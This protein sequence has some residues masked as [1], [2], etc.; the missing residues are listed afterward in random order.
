MFPPLKTHREAFPLH[1]DGIPLQQELNGFSFMPVADEDAPLVLFER[2]F[3]PVERKSSSGM[4]FDLDLTMLHYDP[5]LTI[6]KDFCAFLHY[7]P[8]LTIIKD[9][10]AFVNRIVTNFSFFAEKLVV[11]EPSFLKERAHL[12]PVVFRKRVAVLFKPCNEGRKFVEKRSSVIKIEVGPERFVHAAHARHILEA[13]A[14]EPLDIKRER[15][16]AVGVRDDVRK[17]R[18]ERDLLVVLSCRAFDDTRKACIPSEGSYRFERTLIRSS[19]PRVMTR[20]F[21]L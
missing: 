1:R 17:L 6:I 7:D 13:A 14:R 18:G 19:R 3:R 8:I 12:L 9:F 5:I 10:C 15:A 16:L 20:F 11:R 2:S 4:R 21:P